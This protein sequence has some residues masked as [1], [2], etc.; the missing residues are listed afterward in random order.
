MGEMERDCTRCGAIHTEHIATVAY[1]NSCNECG[2]YAFLAGEPSYLYLLTNVQLKL[3]KVGIGTVGK[4]KDHLEQLIQTG[5]KVHGLWHA[6]DKGQTF[7]WEK[8]VF[9]QLQSQFDSAGAA[10][11]IGRSDRHWFESVSAA[12][13]SLNSLTH[14]MSTVVLGTVK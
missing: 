13:I 5:W 10:G 12:A 11:F 2:R 7:Q 4:D 1:G 14:L 3:H 6:V 8:E 9:K